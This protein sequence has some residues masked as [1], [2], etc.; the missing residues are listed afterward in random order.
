MKEKPVYIMI[1]QMLV[2]PCLSREPV[3]NIRKIFQINPLIR[4]KKNVFLCW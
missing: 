1:P 3:E 4:F 2:L